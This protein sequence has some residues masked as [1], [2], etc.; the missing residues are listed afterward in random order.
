M[1][2]F[3]IIGFLIQLSPLILY[4]VFFKKINKIAGLR[5][6][7]FYVLASCAS[8]IL[9]GAFKNYQIKIISVFEII[10]FALFSGFYFFF[11]QSVKFKRFIVVVSSLNLILDLILFFSLRL[12]F[13]F[14]AT[15]TTAIIIVIYSIFFFSEQV[16]SPVVLAI[17]QSYAFWIVV[18]CIVYIMG[19]FLLFLYTSDLKDKDNSPLWIINIAFE[20]IKNICFSIAFLVAGNNNKHNILAQNFNDTNM[21]EKPF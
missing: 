18:G 9:M 6:V 1:A 4:F 20:I 16:N 14:W 8:I 15:L 10:E 3:V 5:V 13:D 11:I 7:F 17:Y 19:T 12:N 21:L 2:L